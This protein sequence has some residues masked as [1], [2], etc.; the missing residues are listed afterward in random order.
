A[1]H[2]RNKMKGVSRLS[3]RRL[4]M[5]M[6]IKEKCIIWGMGNDYETILNQINFEI[7]KGNIE[8]AAIVCRKED[9]YCEYRDGFPIVLRE[10]IMDLD[11]EYVII[12][13][14][15]FF[16]EIREEA[17]E[18]GIG[19]NRIINGQIFKK[20]LFDFRL[21]SKLIKNPVTILTDDC[22]GGV[23]VSSF[24]IGIFKPVNQYILG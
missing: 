19:A 13:S 9:K 22:W 4:E 16:K 6:A 18:L 8:I 21:Y 12:S 24:R 2:A 11:F 14:S 3:T 1:F 7:Y 5:D 15:A 20:A 23:C 17:I 10:E